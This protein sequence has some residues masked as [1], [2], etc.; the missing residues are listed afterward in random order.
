MSKVNTNLV[1]TTAFGLYGNEVKQIA[2]RHAHHYHQEE[3]EVHGDANLI[4]VKAVRSWNGRKGRLLPRI[5]SLLARRLADKRRVEASRHRLLPRADADLMVVPNQERFDLGRFVLELSD[6]A[7]WVIYLA[8]SADWSIGVRTIRK[9]IREDLVQCD[10][11]LER[12]QAVFLEIRE[13]LQ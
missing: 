9:R 2:H 12:I 5:R 8:I 1:A 3:D 7:A 4:F 10:W 6:D 13:A 11:T